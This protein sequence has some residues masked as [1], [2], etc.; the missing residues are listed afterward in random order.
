[1][2]QQEEGNRR[3]RRRRRRKKGKKSCLRLKLF[4]IEKLCLIPPLTF[5]STSDL[6]DFPRKI[7]ARNCW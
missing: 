7:I 6:P 1:L 5:A 2:E 4:Q 3:R